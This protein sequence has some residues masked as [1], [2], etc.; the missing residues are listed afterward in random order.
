MAACLFDRY[1]RIL[2]PQCAPGPGI[3]NT[4]TKSSKKKF[5]PRQLKIS[6]KNPKTFDMSS[7]TQ[8][9]EKLVQFLYG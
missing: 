4:E 7:K 5:I 6:Q 9:L 8:F 3:F 1:S 2:R